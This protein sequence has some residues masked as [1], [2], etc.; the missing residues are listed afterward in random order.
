MMME[1]MNDDDLW[2][3][4]SHCPNDTIRTKEV[5]LGPQFPPPPFFD[6][7]FFSKSVSFWLCVLIHCRGCESASSLIPWLSFLKT[8]FD[9]IVLGLAS[10]NQCLF[11]FWRRFAKLLPQKFL[12]EI[13]PCKFLFL[14]SKLTRRKF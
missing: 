6:P 5:F 13:F 4:F 14:N 12:I 2:G 8:R 1:R 10:C 9:F 7:S 3:F 11:F